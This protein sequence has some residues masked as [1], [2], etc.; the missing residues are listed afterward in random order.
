VVLD[1]T[2]AS[3]EMTV[4]PEKK[5]TKAKIGRPT[6]YL[7]SMCARVVK[8]GTAGKSKAQIARTLGVSRTTMDA[9]AAEYPDFLHA[10]KV[11][12]DIA[13]AW[14]EDQGQSGLKAQKFNATAFIFQMKNRFPRD[15]RDQQIHEHGGPD[16]SPIP[17]R[18][19]SL[20]DA[21]LGQLVSRIE[22]AISSRG[23]QS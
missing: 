9:W 15:Y 7:P 4:S 12:G 3:A 21:Q 14:W 5:Q 6:K 8:L 18:L 19:E 2:R 1:P 22:A 17:V 20:S 10:V 11:S 13:L 16:G 23:G